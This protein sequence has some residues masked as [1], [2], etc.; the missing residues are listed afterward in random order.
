MPQHV[1]ECILSDDFSSTCRSGT[2]IP[3]SNARH[4]LLADS[5]NGQATLLISVETE[6]FVTNPTIDIWRTS[7]NFKSATQLNFGNEGMDLPGRFVPC[8]I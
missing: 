5:S 7:L 2:G 6:G 1:R 4:T 3:A 8:Q